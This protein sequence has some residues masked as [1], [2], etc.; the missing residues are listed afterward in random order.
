M[1]KLIGGA[2]LTQWTNKKTGWVP[3]PIKNMFSGIVSWI[4]EFRPGNETIWVVFDEEFNFLGSRRQFLSLESRPS[5]LKERVPYDSMN[6]YLWIRF[7]LT[8]VSDLIWFSFSNQRGECTET[9][10]KREATSWSAF[11]RSR[12][13]LFKMF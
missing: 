13:L 7:S 5:F 11:R 6:N 8:E 12:S 3:K 1:S 10:T 4:L 2:K 9:H